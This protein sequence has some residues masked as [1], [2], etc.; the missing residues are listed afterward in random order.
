MVCLSGSIL[1]FILFLIII[2]KTYNKYH[3]YIIDPNC[4][5][6]CKDADFPCFN[7]VYPNQ[8]AHTFEQVN[9]L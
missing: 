4:V 1:F 8:N 7:Y 9:F 6:K 2:I 3:K 5:Q